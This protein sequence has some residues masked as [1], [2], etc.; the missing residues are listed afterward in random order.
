M[1]KRELMR[2]K[3][4]KRDKKNCVRERQKKCVREKE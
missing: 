2:V 1:L 4:S 3:Q